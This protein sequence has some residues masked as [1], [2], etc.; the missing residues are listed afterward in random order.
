L[1]MEF[2]SLFQL[3]DG[4]NKILKKPIY[5]VWEKRECMC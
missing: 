5:S 2:F 1:G 4:Q 3:T